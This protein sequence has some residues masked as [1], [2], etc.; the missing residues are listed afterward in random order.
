MESKK[1]ITVNIVNRDYPPYK[2][3]TGE[4]AAELAKYLL[5]AGFQVNIIHTDAPFWGVND[6]IPTGNIFKVK[7]LYYGK[8]KLL[9]LFAN[10]LSGYFL[11]KKSK[12]IPCDVT[13]VMTDPS[14]I[15]MW[16]SLLLKKGKWILWAMDLYPESF[17]AGKL[18]SEN[19]YLYEKLYQLTVKNAPRHIIS[20]GPLQMIHLQNR[21]N[22]S[23]SN[24]SSLPCGIYEAKESADSESPRWANDTTKICLG[25]CGNLGAA[26]SL[27]FLYAIADHLD[28]K[29]FKMVISVYG[30]KAETLKH[31]VQG[32]SGVELIPPVKR[33]HL[34]YIDIH[35]ASLLP[36]WTHISVPSKTVSSVC[37][38]SAFLYYGEEDSDN[39]FLLKD[40]GW[41]IPYGENIEKEVIRFLQ[42]FDG[43]DLEQKKEAAQKIAKKLTADKIQAF[44]EI[45]TNI[46]HQALE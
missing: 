30:L 7:T 31:Y 2:G 12:K 18:I 44:R 6:S 1:T 22:R 4:S 23:V 38:G 36:Q 10:L 9:R 8:N 34:K 24:F 33:E 43:K 39:W 32:K 13:I 27:E 20:L 25:Y 42:Q 37:A 16:A 41:L 5:E 17:A 14:L 28:I 11:I 40:A 46:Q 15:N 45:A 26:H 21:Y 19:N 35:L 29:K 3:I